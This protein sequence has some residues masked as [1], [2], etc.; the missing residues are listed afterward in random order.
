MKKVNLSERTLK[1]IKEIATT[2]KSK[3]KILPEID[4]KNVALAFKFFCQMSKGYDISPLEMYLAFIKFIGY[5]NEI[6]EEIETTFDGLGI[7]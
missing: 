2:N 7:A 4:D 6:E 5:C 3:I 1:R